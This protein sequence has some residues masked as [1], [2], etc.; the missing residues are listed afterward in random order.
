[1][2]ISQDSIANLFQRLTTVLPDKWERKRGSLG[3]AQVLYTI[4]HM[5]AD[6]IGSYQKSLDYL[7]REVGDLLGW[8]TEPWSSSLSESRRKLSKEQCL[9]AFRESRT[10][11]TALQGMPKV[12]YKDYRL[13]AVD[14]TKLALP[15]YQEIAQEFGCPKDRKGNLAPAPQATLTALWD[16]STNT[17]VDWRLQK[18]YASERFAGYDLVQSLGS[19]DLLLADRG[20][21]SRRILKQLADQ[22]SAY[23][24]R[25]PGGK[26]GG[27]IEVRNFRD[28][29]TAWDREVWLHEKN[30]RKGEPTIRVRLMKRRL[31]NGDLAIFAT[32]LFGSRAHRRRALCDLYC[33]RWDIE[34]AFKEMKMWHGLENFKARYAEGI[35]QE[36]AGLM[37]FMLLTAE[38]EAQARRY[39]EVP[40]ID[41]SDQGPS[42]PEFRF[43]RKIIATTVA[44]LLA[45]ACEGPDSIKNEFDYSMK[46]L[47]RYRQRRRPGRKFERI[48]KDPNSKY[49]KS[50]YNA[51][52]TLKKSRSLA[53]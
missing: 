5:S 26:A 6:G 24:I 4:I 45:A 43:N 50:T 22:G 2:D 41:T 51:S 48:A 8:E 28:D 20:Y 12:A 42:E 33:Y 10:C 13:V 39:H 1:M 34:T 47:W 29:S 52:K 44:Y 18:V 31:N 36:V 9:L 14:M 49:K 21:P 46:R 25:M 40:M 19:D 16:I 3:P 38:I 15:A 53:E 23:L 17:P 27:F 35:H 32:N 7:K 11:C 37:L 30:D